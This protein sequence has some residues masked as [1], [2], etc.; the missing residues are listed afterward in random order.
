MS[1]KTA[2]ALET[3]DQDIEFPIISNSLCIK[4]AI[5]FFMKLSNS[6]EIICRFNLGIDLGKKVSQD[7]KT[8]EYEIFK[9]F[10]DS[11]WKEVYSC[12]K[13]LL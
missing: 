1:S 13:L 11:I 12:I 4:Q 7:Y 9:E 10:F 3:N 2:R 6:L 5:D 8:A